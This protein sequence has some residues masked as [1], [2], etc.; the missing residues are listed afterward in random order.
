MLR[1]CYSVETDTM[2]VNRSAAQQEA[3]RA[4]GA[5]SKG[6]ITAEGKA[7]ASRN[8][9]RHG[10]TSNRTVMTA[11]EI[12]LA[13]GLRAGYVRRYV[14]EDQLELEVVEGL[15]MIQI[16]LR[17]PDRLEL[18]AM[19]RAFETI[20]M[21]EPDELE[22]QKKYPSLAT[23]GRYRGRLNHERKLAE[24]RLDRLL[25]E[26]ASI[27]EAPAAHQLRFMA[28]LVEDLEA[29]QP[30]NENEVSTNEPDSP[31]SNISPER[32]GAVAPSYILNSDAA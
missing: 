11:D 30:V 31:A 24:Q 25:L 9:V 15:V 28:D 2:S 14:P 29:K 7:K 1:R 23:L 17:R 19:D 21:N 3:A 16:K 20:D 22:A 6:P 32:E 4:N 10:F 12:Q 18:E 13:E 26:R 27:K 5:K 8:A